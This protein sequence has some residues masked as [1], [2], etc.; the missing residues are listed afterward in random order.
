MTVY[1]LV[2]ILEFWAMTM[3]DLDRSTESP[4][5]HDLVCELQGV[6]TPLRCESESIL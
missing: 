4:L 5:V 6:H 3:T 2:C 1:R